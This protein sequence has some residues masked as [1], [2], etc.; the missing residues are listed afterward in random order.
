MPTIASKINMRWAALKTDSW[1]LG[2]R[3]VHSFCTFEINSRTI[4]LTSQN[5]LYIN[6]WS[7]IFLCHCTNEKE[8]QKYWT[9]GSNLSNFP[10]WWAAYCIL[11][12]TPPDSGIFVPFPWECFAAELALDRIRLVW[13]GFGSLD[14]IGPLMVACLGTLTR[15]EAAINTRQCTTK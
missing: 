13:V 5:Q 2:L 11:W 14:R 7:L 12:R 6:V 8:I 3:K 1:N 9:F 15:E 10:W 4:P